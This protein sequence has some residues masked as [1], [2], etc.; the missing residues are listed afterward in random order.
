M[1]TDFQSEHH[2]PMWEPLE[3][4]PVRIGNV[5]V[6]AHEH[7]LGAQ[8]AGSLRRSTVE[9]LALQLGQ[10]LV[11]VVSSRPLAID[12]APVQFDSGYALKI[13]WSRTP[14][15]YSRR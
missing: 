15:S 13:E 4:G 5:S 8:P 14:R 6:G 3:R 2:D 7:G 1:L 12:N 10:L 9:W 11:E